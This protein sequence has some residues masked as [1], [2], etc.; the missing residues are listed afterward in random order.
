[1]LAGDDD[2]IVPVVNGRILTALIPHARLEII[3]GGGHL[4]PLERPT[5]IAALLAEFLQ[6]P[7]VQ[8]GVGWRVG[9]G[10]LSRT[11]G[12]GGAGSRSP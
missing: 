6:R 2:P 7:C 4:F 12:R 11:L 3:R 1:M 9:H 10:G 8:S 5:E